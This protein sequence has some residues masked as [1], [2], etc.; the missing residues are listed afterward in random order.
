MEKLRAKLETAQRDL[1]TFE[2]RKI[3]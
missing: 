1:K 3:K 2:E